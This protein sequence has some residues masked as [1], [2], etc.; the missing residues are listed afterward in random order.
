TASGATILVVD[1]M[2]ALR[3]IIARVLGARGY[4]VLSVENAAEAE[5]A[6]SEEIHLLMTD[7]VLRRGDA[8][9][10][11]SRVRSRWPRVR[12]LYMSGYGEGA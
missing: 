12:V 1:D 4:R 8:R 6:A 3:R 9:E 7:A 2:E 10:V 5:R 11:V